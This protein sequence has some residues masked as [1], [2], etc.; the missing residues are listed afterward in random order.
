M[1]LSDIMSNMGLAI[2]P[3]VALLMFLAV[4]IAVAWRAMRS[5]REE[6]DVYACLPLSDDERGAGA[7][8]D[9]DPGSNWK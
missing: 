1:R 7:K 5:R 9:A 2:Y 3:T 8:G 6:L 4:F